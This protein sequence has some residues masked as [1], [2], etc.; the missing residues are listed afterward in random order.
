MVNG[1]LSMIRRWVVALLVSN[2]CACG[3]APPTWTGAEAP[4]LSATAANR[5]D[6]NADVRVVWVLRTQDCLACQRADYTVRS[7]KRRFRDRVE[8]E[9]A[10]VGAVEDSA[11]VAGFVTQYRLDATVTHVSPYHFK[12]LFRFRQP[13]FI[14][15]VHEDRVSWVTFEADQ[16]DNDI[17]TH[18]AALLATGEEVG[19]PDQRNEHA[20]N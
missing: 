14:Y 18:I 20:T 11:I 15:V 4:R 1:S 12:R 10:H 6:Q 3:E 13:P 5:L 16:E 9:L 2:L 8:I 7:L 19:K 17:F